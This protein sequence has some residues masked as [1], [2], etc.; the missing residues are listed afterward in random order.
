MRVA[1]AN[2]ID[3]NIDNHDNIVIVDCVVPAINPDGDPDFYFV[4]VR[5]PVSKYATGHH[6][7]AATRAASD[8]DYEPGSVVFDRA[9]AEDFPWLF[10]HFAWDTAEIYSA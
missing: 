6:Y 5:L 1:D 9:D 3:I 10:E 4:R 2:G 7:D 8:N